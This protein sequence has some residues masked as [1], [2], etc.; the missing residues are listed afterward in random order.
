MEK[1]KIIKVIGAA[2]ETVP[3]SP[4]VSFGALLF[5]SGQVSKDLKTGNPRPGTI[6]EETEQVLGN[7]EAILKEAGSSPKHVI[8]TTV[9]LRS[10]E[11][12]PK[13][14][15]VYRRHFPEES[16]A[17]STVGVTLAGNYKVEIEAVAYVSGKK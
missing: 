9:F 13:M 11:E 16:P 15:E 14:N 10:I 17:R 4:G 1:K 6:E 12:F 2:P 3:L 5:I 8:K 7:I